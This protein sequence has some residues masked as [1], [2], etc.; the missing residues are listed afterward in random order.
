MST[1]QCDRP[2]ETVLRDS[3]IRAA[4]RHQLSAEHCADTL[5]LDELGLACSTARVDVAVL[6]GSMSGFEIKSDVDSLARLPRQVAAYDSILDFATLVAGTR[7]FQHARDV[8]P[9]H[10][11]LVR[12]E[13][14]DGALN[15]T[16]VRPA[17]HNARVVPRN[18]AMMLWREE[19][20]EELK[21]RQAYRGLSAKPKGA[22][23][24]ALVGA[25]SVD[26][27]RNLVRERVKARG[28]W[29]AAERRT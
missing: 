6:N 8:V 24:D 29:R 28:D 20:V 16:M 10:W 22:L 9:E 12:A 27:L 4:L 13:V 23:W 19:L 7:H 17:M 21:A 25:T 1:D 11:G 26:E 3:D 2:R 18:L 14:L 5:I 15:L